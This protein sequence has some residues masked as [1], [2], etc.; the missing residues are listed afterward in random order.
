M[1]IQP[2]RFKQSSFHDITIN[3]SPSKL[4]ALAI[5]YGI[6][7]QE[8]N[9]GQDKTNF[10]FQFE[11]EEGLYFTV[12]DWKEYRFVKIEEVIEFHIGTTGQ[13]E[14]WEAYDVLMDE[15]NDL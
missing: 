7:F 13:Q 1:L 11:T 4:M 8:C 10:D 14:S 15:L 9:T 12:Y 5:K 3:T 2:T 6:E